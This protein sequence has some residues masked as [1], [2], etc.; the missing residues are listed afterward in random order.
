MLTSFCVHPNLKADG[1]GFIRLSQRTQPD[2]IN[3][4]ILGPMIL[5]RSIVPF[6]EFA[7]QLPLHLTLLAQ[8]HKILLENGK[9]QEKKP[10]ISATSQLVLTD[11][12]LKFRTVCK[13]TSGLCK[14]S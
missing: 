3:P 9:K 4:L 2:R 1:M 14:L 12:S 7:K 6:Q 5:Q 10:V 11:A 13:I 8:F